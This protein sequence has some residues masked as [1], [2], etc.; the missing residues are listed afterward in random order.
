MKKCLTILFLFLFPV[1]A[2]SQEFKAGITSGFVV[3]QV[4]GDDLG[5]YNKAGITFG[6]FVKR[7]TKNK[8]DFG[9][10]IK[11]IQ[12]GSADGT[13]FEKGDYNSYK[14]RLSYIEIPFIAKYNFTKKIIFES[15]LGFSYL[16]KATENE[17]NQGAIPADPEYNKFELPFICGANYELSE[18]I[19]LSGRFSYSVLPIRAYPGGQK[20]LLDWGQCNKLLSLSLNFKI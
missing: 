9:T 17:N 2:F 4:N 19:E 8:V 5:G 13:D 18:K 7:E 20:H 16:I 6:F 12:K 14:L 3:S 10:E 15:G 1:I 11:Y